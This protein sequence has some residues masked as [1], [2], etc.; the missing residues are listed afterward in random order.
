MRLGNREIA[1]RCNL[2][3][4]TVS[5]LTLTLIKIGQLEYLP[6]DQTYRIGPSTL[7]L[8]ETLFGKC[9]TERCHL[10]NGGW[11]RTNQ[12]SEGTANRDNRDEGLDVFGCDP[13]GR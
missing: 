10:P 11:N 4:S 8:G 2:P 7:A 3:R 6:E 9:V 5:R 13:D 1:E 12:T